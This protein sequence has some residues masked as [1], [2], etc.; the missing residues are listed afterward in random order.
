MPKRAKRTVIDGE[1][2]ELVISLRNYFERECQNDGPLL[3]ISQVSD[4]VAEAFG[5]GRSTDINSGSRDF[6]TILRNYFE[7]ECQNGGPLLPISQVIDRV[8]DALSIGRNTV[9]RITKE[10]YGESSMEENVL[11]TPNKLRKRRK[12][13][14]S[15]TAVDSFVEYSSNVR[16][17]RIADIKLKVDLVRKKL[18]TDFQI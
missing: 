8:A 11:S 2:R 5:I 12:K 6:V 18:R 9:S 4:R 13:K 14:S 16:D 7:R 15:I 1:S 10:K 3:P 17:F